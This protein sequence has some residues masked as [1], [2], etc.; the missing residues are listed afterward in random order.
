MPPPTPAKVIAIV[1]S[2]NPKILPIIPSPTASTASGPC[3]SRYAAL[4]MYRPA[5]AMSNAAIET[6][7]CPFSV[8]RASVAPVRAIG[9][10]A[11]ALILTRSPETSF[12]S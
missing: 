4:R 8:Y 2:T 7:E 1:P 5:V 11:A 3:L 9:S 12:D 10:P 6:P